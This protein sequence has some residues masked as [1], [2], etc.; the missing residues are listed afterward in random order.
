MA[1]STVLIGGRSNERG[2]S[3]RGRDPDEV[4][5][6]GLWCIGAVV[7]GQHKLHSGDVVAILLNDDLSRPGTAPWVDGAK[8]GVEL[9]QG[10]ASQ[11]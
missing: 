1:S 7:R 10:S 11:N 5:P 4:Q 9:L 3:F 2:A 8:F 6:E